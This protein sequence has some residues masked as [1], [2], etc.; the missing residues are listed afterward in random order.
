MGTDAL[1][2]DTLSRVIYGARTSLMVG[3]IAVGIAASIGMTLGLIAGYFGGI[4]YTIIMRFMDALMSF[5]MILLALVIAALLGGGL[6]NVMIALGIGLMPGYARLMCGQVLSVKENDYIMAGRA[7]GAS[8]L[9][10]MLRHILPNCLPATHS[11][12]DYD[13]GDGYPG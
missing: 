13:D 7:I 8:N 10:I 12:D 5:P 1:G 9:R 11:T 3:I 6:K 4:T 2:R